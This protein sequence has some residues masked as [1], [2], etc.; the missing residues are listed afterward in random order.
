MPI[1][2]AADDIFNLLILIIVVL[3]VVVVVVVFRKNETTFHVKVTK[4]KL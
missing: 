4:L 2:T 1:K 3:V